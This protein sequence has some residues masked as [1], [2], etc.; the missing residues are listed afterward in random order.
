MASTLETNKNQTTTTES[1]MLI[2]WY[3]C[4]VSMYKQHANILNLEC[5]TLKMLFFSSKKKRKLMQ[6][7]IR[8]FKITL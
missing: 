2:F 5:L 1:K 4:Y 3:L 6:T 8:I 7:L